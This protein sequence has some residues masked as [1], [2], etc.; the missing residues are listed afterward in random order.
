MP[1]QQDESDDAFEK[2]SD[3]RQIG[4]VIGSECTAEAF[5][6]GKKHFVGLV[7]ENRQRCKEGI[8]RQPFDSVTLRGQKTC[9]GICRS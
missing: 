7:P 2:D 3:K 9:V 8:Y 6:W 5:C 1:A 4:K